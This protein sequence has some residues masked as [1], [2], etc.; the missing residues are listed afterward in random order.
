MYRHPVRG[1][2]T[3]EFRAATPPPLASP[4]SLSH[5]SDTSKGRRI[6]PFWEAGRF[7]AVPDPNAP[8]EQAT[9]GLGVPPG[10]EGLLSMTPD[11][12]TELYAAHRLAATYPEQPNASACAASHAVF[13]GVVPPGAL[14]FNA[15]AYVRRPMSGGEGGPTPATD[16]EVTDDVTLPAHPLVRY[17]NLALAVGGY[18]YW[19]RTN[20]AITRFTN[21]SAEHLCR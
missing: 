13:G 19:D 7:G 18:H 12:L 8:S 14:W 4:A 6:C 9:L 20:P 1:L 11:A 2:G 5:A 21:A 15:S 16:D 10:P 3:A 17:T